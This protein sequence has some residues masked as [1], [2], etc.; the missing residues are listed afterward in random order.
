[1]V[2]LRLTNQGTNQL[3]WD[4]VVA[5]NRDNALLLASYSRLEALLISL[6]VFVDQHERFRNSLH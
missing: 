6:S 5:P 3:I 4:K 1:M 2:G